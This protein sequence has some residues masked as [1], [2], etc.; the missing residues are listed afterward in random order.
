[1]LRSGMRYMLWFTLLPGLL[2]AGCKPITDTPTPVPTAAVTKELLTRMPLPQGLFGS[3]YSAFPVGPDSGYQT[4]QKFAEGTIDPNDTAAD[5][6][7]SGWLATYVLDFS[8][9]SLAAL[10]N[11]AGAFGAQSELDLFKDDQSASAFISKELANS[12]RLVGQNVANGFILVAASQFD[13]ATA[14]PGFGLKSQVRFGT[15]NFYDWTAGF[16]L[17]RLVATVFLS[18]ADGMDLTATTIHLAQLLNQRVHNLISGSIQETPVPIPSATPGSI[19]SAPPPPQGPYPDRMV[20]AV[21]DLPAGATVKKEGYSAGSAEF[22]RDFN[23]PASSPYLDIESDATLFGSAADSMST[24]AVTRSLFTSGSAADFFNQ[25]F[26]GE[27]LPFQ[28]A[29][30][31]VSSA[32]IAPAG[33]ENF[34]VIASYDSPIGR[35]ENEFVYVRV[36]PVIGLIITTEQAGSLQQS[37][38]DAL[39]ATLAAHIGQELAHPGASPNG[40]GA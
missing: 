34:G 31:T 32:A 6:E 28:L 39:I 21:N 4:S 40:A 15:E 12:A 11:G 1:M 10:S 23:L 17:G 14:D 20:L 27:S 26:K 9:P 25:V 16:R 35:I 24:Y 18:R 2:V 13:D 36:G 7:N 19:G 3:D 38:I 29:N 5:V 37:E 8:D 33:D 22:K 30:T